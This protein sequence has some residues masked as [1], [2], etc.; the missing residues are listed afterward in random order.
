[1]KLEVMR[2]ARRAQP[3]LVLKMWVL[4]VLWCL[5][6]FTSFSAR[7]ATPYQEVNSPSNKYYTFKFGLVQA[8]VLSG[9]EPYCGGSLPCSVYT[10]DLNVGA[11]GVSPQ[12]E[13]LAKHLTKVGHMTHQCVRVR[14]GFL[15][16][17]ILVHSYVCH[18]GSPRLAL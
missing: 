7:W 13:W 4:A 5:Q 17:V 2:A 3:H 14:V 11:S 9:Y 16:F 6:A 8:F 1:M 12:Y 10:P 15:I 18:P